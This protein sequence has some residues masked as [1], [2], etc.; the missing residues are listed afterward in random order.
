M[1]ND[2]F[3]R[4]DVNT[5]AE[6]LEVISPL[7]ERWR[8]GNWFFRGVSSASWPL[9]PSLFR[10]SLDFLSPTG[11]YTGMVFEG[12]QRRGLAMLREPALP[13]DRNNV[14]MYRELEW[15][16]LAHFLMQANLHGFPVPE[17]DHW[18]TTA[19]DDP[20]IN[21]GVLRFGLW[22][23]NRIIHQLAFAQHHGVPTRLLDWSISPYFAAWFAASGAVHS[24]YGHFLA[25]EA[26]FY[27]SPDDARFSIW[28]I[29]NARSNVLTVGKA[30]LE[31]IMPSYHLNTRI[32]AQK[33]VFTLLR[34]VEEDAEVEMLSHD[35]F[36]HDKVSATSPVLVQITAPHQ[37]APSVLKALSCLGVD[38]ATIYP[39]V[40]SIPLAH[41]D[42]HFATWL[43]TLNLLQ[44]PEKQYIPRGARKVHFYL[45]E[46]RWKEVEKCARENDR[47]LDGAA[48]RLLLR[49]LSVELTEKSA[50]E[51]LTAE[52]PSTETPNA[53]S[54]PAKKP[55]SDRKLSSK[56]PS[57]KSSGKKPFAE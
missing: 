47:G 26:L 30:S 31:I 57:K 43:D 11:R 44:E 7:H 25:H 37:I 56:K 52:D 23:I 33:G 46:P 14:L 2:A 50:A 36:V 19:K 40:E 8:D 49:G 41:L 6:F 27:S 3:A 22:P 16:M 24:L 35:K 1:S 45:T 29:C 13:V 54:L 18:W 17:Y 55:L 5:T 34:G 32:N 12:A 20:D 38:R 10:M 28:A 4:I 48:L 51:E 15:R 53:E 42:H 39:A 21:D 9:I